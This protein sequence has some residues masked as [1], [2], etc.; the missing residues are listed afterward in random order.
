MLISATWRLVISLQV[1]ITRSTSVQ[2]LG[3]NQTLII[4]NV[5]ITTV[6][7]GYG[8]DPL[9]PD[10]DGDGYLDGDEIKTGSD[11]KDA[12]NSSNL[13]AYYNFERSSGN[14]LLTK[15]LGATT[16]TLDRPDHTRCRWW[17]S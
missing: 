2:E 8:L 12:N 16:P 13:L 4:D 11:P 14:V 5:V 9:S 1:M 3:A 15:V 7:S 6:P 17:C 10:F